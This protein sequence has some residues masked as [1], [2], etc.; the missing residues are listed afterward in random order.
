MQKYIAFLRGINVGGHN[1]LPMQD[2]RALMDLLGFLEVKTYIQTGNIVFKSDET[3]IAIITSKIEAGIENSFGFKIPVLI[4]TPKQVALILENYPFSE[5]EKQTSYFALL[6]T[7]AGRNQKQLI[8]T[9]SFLNEKFKL[10]ND[11]VYLYSSTGYGRAKANNNFLEKKLEITV[12]TRN[13][14]TLTKLLV[15]SE[16]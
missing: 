7:K 8:T 1:K 5:T 11:C 9:F 10:I 6:Y 15:L 3:D 14:K 4:K 16:A 2:L 13:F 12:T